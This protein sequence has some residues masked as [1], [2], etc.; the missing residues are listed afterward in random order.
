MLKSKYDYQTIFA[1]KFPGHRHFE[2]YDVIW[3]PLLLVI[4][5]LLCET[6]EQL[7]YVMKSKMS[8]PGKFKSENRR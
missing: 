8:V 6:I 3:L 4:E 1:F 2:F 5:V 7:Y